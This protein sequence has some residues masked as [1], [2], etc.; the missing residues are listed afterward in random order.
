[1]TLLRI[2]LTGG[3]A[4][5]KTTIGHM[6]ED[7]GACLAQAD[8]IAHDLMRPGEPVYA[9]VVQHFG[10][11]I[12]HVDGSIDRAR[13]A[14]AVFG[15]GRVEELNGIVHPAVIASQE[16]WLSDMERGSHC[17]VAIVEAALILEAGVGRRFDK[18]VV[19]T[20]R[21]EQKVERFAERHHVTPEAAQAEVERRQAVQWPDSEKIAA[22][23]YVI[24]NSGSL[25]YARQQ[26]ASIYSE[27]QILAG[28]KI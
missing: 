27:L 5:G 23:D 25:D 6:F 24:D 1:M 10:S 7:L 28:A 18:L 15:A 2:G 11:D 17:S 26:V 4:C 22:A 13:L 14:Q 3:I 21:P 8:Q 12:V 9:Q 16:K 20:C 19:V